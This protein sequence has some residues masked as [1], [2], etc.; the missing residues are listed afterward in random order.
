MSPVDES[1]SSPSPTEYL[2]KKFD[3]AKENLS[4]DPYSPVEKSQFGSKKGQRKQ[5]PESWYNY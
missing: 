1:A 3:S 2:R 4:G 5:Q